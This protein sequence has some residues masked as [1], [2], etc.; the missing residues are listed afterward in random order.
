ML[1]NKLAIIPSSRVP[2]AD[3]SNGIVSNVW[4]RW[5]NAVY[6]QLTSVRVTPSFRVYLT[7]ALSL[8]GTSFW[9]IPYDT[10]DW[11][12]TDD[13]NTVSGVWIPKVSGIYNVTAS[14]GLNTSQTPDT[15][16]QLGLYKNG[17]RERYLFYNAIT[18]TSVAPN[19][20]GVDNVSITAGDSYMVVT[21]LNPLSPATSTDILAGSPSTWFSAAFQAPSYQA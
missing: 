21:S 18:S 20:S 4:F 14:L 5:F 16:I 17:V 9:Q 3:T 8:A 2:I 1:D 7:G 19:I 15:P 6:S 11:D 12:T 13:F 10:V